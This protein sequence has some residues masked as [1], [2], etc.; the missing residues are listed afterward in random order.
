MV[1]EV[2]QGSATAEFFIEGATL[3]V[4]VE[5]TVHIEETF[6]GN[7]LNNLVVSTVE[8]VASVDGETVPAGASL[9]LSTVSIDI[10]PGS[11]PN[12]INQGSGGNVPVAIFST[13]TFDATSVNPLTVTLASAPVKLKGKGTPMSSLQ[14]V[15]GD[16]LLDLVVHVDTS[17]LQISESDTDAVLRGETNTGLKIIGQDSIRVVP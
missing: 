3:V 8:G 11:F 13:P 2:L 10:K 12:S 14:D 6:S 16:G 4:V 17:A 1:L 5:G 15:N 9:T 7:A